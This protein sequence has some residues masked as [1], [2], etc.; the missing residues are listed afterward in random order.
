MKLEPKKVAKPEPKKVAKPEPKR[1]EKAERKKA[2]RL[3]RKKVVNPHGMTP[4]KQLRRMR[5]SAHSL[6]H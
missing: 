6:P 1:V 2:A 3:E 4:L 5:T